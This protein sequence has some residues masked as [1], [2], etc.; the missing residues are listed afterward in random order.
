[1]ARLQYL[2]AVVFAHVQ[3]E[4]GLLMQLDVLEPQLPRLLGHILSRHCPANG[5]V[6]F[7]LVRPFREGEALEIADAGFRPDEDVDQDHDQGSHPGL[8]DPEHH[9][10]VGVARIPVLDRPGHGHDDHEG[11]AADNIE[12]VVLAAA[13]VAED[14]DRYARGELIG[15]ALLGKQADDQQ[16]R[17][18][19]YNRGRHTDHA[20]VQGHSVGQ[21]VDRGGAD[22]GPVRFV[23]VHVERD[24]VDDRDRKGRLDLFT[25]HSFT[26][27]GRLLRSSGRPGP[28]MQ[29][30]PQPWRS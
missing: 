28:I 26:G 11:D 3:D 10:L 22:R 8:G 14:Q 30:R 15:P 2:E 4:V 23:P 12:V 1:M 29:A 13:A 9:D 5:M 7:S 18:A 17:E 24:R 19:A 20:P 25:S 6:Q 16:P 21:Q 27:H